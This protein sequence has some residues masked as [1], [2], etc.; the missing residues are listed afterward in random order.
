VFSGGNSPTTAARFPRGEAVHYA[1]HAIALGVSA[2]AIIIEPRAA[3]TG[4]NIDYSRDALTRAGIPV[5]SVMLIS[6]PLRHPGPDPRHRG[7]DHGRRSARGRQRARHDH[8]SGAGG[9]RYLERAP[10][11]GLGLAVTMFTP[12][13]HAADLS[14]ENA[15]R[16]SVLADLAAARLSAAIREHAQ[17]LRDAGTSTGAH[18]WAKWIRQH[19]ERTDP[20]NGQLRLVE[21]TSCS[22][23]E[24]QPHM[25]GWSTYGPYR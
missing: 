19:A 24:L 1:E 16:V 18:E 17:L 7:N 14:P 3:N 25:R 15:R 20:L 5:T 2:G 4:Q 12:A 10:F 11:A 13:E 6:R 21:V 22:H 23:E 9:S 8:L